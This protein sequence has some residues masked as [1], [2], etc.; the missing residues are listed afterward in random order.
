MNDRADLKLTKTKTFATGPI[1]LYY[2]AVKK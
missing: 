2:E 1:M